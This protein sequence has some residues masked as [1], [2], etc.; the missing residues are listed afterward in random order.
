MLERLINL[1]EIVFGW[2]SYIAIDL[3]IKCLSDS[4]KI[5]LIFFIVPSNLKVF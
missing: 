3:T 2:L 5:V 1:N 4:N